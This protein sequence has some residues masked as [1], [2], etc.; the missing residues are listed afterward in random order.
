MINE[1]VFI[2]KAIFE[3]NEF[4]QKHKGAQKIQE[5]ESPSVM[6]DI[7][8]DMI[9]GEF[10]EFKR[11]DGNSFSINISPSESVSGEAIVFHGEFV[12][13]SHQ[14]M[15]DEEARAIS[16]KIVDKMV[17]AGII[18]DCHNTD[19]EDE[20]IAQDAIFDEVI[21][22]NTNTSSSITEAQIKHDLVSEFGMSEEE[23][24]VLA[25]QSVAD[26]NSSI[27]KAYLQELSSLSDPGVN[28]TSIVYNIDSLK[29]STDYAELYD[30]L[31]ESIGDFMAVNNITLADLNTQSPTDKIIIH[32]MNSVYLEGNEAQLKFI[33]LALRSHLKSNQLENRHYEDL[34]FDIDEQYKLLNPDLAEHNYDLTD[35]HKNKFGIKV[36]EAGATIKNDPLTLSLNDPDFYDFFTDSPT[37]SSAKWNENLTEI[38]FQF[39]LTDEQVAELEVKL[40]I[41]SLLHSEQT[42]NP[43][44]I[45]LEISKR[46]ELSQQVYNSID[47]LNEDNFEQNVAI[48][49]SN[50]LSELRDKTSGLILK[51]NSGSAYDDGFTVSITDDAGEYVA[52]IELYNSTDD[53][54][55]YTNI[56]ISSDFA[57]DDS[58]YDRLLVLKAISMHEDELVGY[59]PCP[60]I[61]DSAVLQPA[62][63]TLRKAKLISSNDES[64]A[65]TPLGEK[66]LAERDFQSIRFPTMISDNV[67]ERSVSSSAKEKIKG[68]SH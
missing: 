67:K 54:D 5:S 15:N 56:K 60:Q 7:F 43:D 36:M 32:D 27:K 49:I 11:L 1:E 10:G 51:T 65:L 30:I 19:F 61:M 50:R 22:I 59:N 57:A 52:S 28:F 18:R 53:S 64:F 31:N 37:L 9:S 6:E 40:Y 3:A 62:I 26:T 55:P 66:Y 58:G 48:S 4:I 33:S 23:A 24:T 45:F 21:K 46:V 34:C 12:D 8:D 2:E 13:P 20:L 42:R 39:D 47:S 68:M 44:W 41:Y 16:I 17:D 38:K 25:T 35:A 63:R 14:S 29:F